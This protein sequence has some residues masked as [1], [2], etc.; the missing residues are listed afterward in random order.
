MG[1][2]AGLWQLPTSDLG[3]LFRRRDGG[4]RAYILLP[5]IALCVPDAAANAANKVAAGADGGL[6]GAVGRTAVDDVCHLQA[7][8]SLVVAFIVLRMCLDFRVF[9]RL[10]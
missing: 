1:A 7:E 10:L 6:H 9:E 2:C 5:C 4:R 3:G 8:Q